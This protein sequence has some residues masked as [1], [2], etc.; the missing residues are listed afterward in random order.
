MLGFENYINLIEIIM[1]EHHYDNMIDKNYTF[2][3][4]SGFLKQKDF[5]NG[6]QVKDAVQKKLMNIYFLKNN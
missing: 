6:L 3:D 5:K 4:I 1:F 2:S